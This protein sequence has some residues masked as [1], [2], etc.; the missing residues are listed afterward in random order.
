ML[1][2]F[3]AIYLAVVSAAT[4]LLP[5]QGL[6]LST[7][8]MLVAAVAVGVVMLIAL[9][10]RSWRELGV[11]PGERTASEVVVGLAIPC[12]ALLLMVAVLV[13]MR[14]LVYGPDS[15]TVAEWVFGSVQLLLLLAIAAAAEEALFRGY[16]FQKLVEV[17]G[18]VIAT[19]LASA[20]FAFAHGNNPG[21]GGFAL[22]NIFLAGI[23]LSIAYL[24]T[25]SLWFPTAL[26]LGWNWQMAGPLDLPV[27][28]LELFDT[29]LYELEALGTAEITGGGFGPEGGIAGLVTLSVITVAVWFYTR[30]RYPGHD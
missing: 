9:E 8:I 17:T 29:P 13:M 6:V 27:S 25:R 30:Q 1:V 20:G 10:H 4:A 16:P 24:K 14:Q 28:G 26:H 7:L 2:L 12:V 19:L 11:A 18:P 3:I 22:I 5:A 21:I 15:G 23:M